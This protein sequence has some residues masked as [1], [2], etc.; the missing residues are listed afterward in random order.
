MLV[1][2]CSM[3]NNGSESAK[4]EEIERRVLAW[5]AMFPHS[6]QFE[7]VAETQVGEAPAADMFMGLAELSGRVSQAENTAPPTRLSIPSTP[8]MSASWIAAQLG[9]PKWY[10]K[11][12]TS[13]FN[14]RSGIY[15]VR[16]RD[17]LH[18]SSG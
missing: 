9:K 15:N 17:R 2:P 13:R 18:S 16:R 3:G 1:D 11:T 8:D 5:M 12:S 6:G 7:H 4:S 10:Y 14:S